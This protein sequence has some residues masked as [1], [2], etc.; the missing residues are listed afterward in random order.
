MRPALLL[1]EIVLFLRGLVV[2]MSRSFL[3][4]TRQWVTRVV[5]G[6]YS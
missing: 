6:Q 3:P 4:R 2:L 5:A 1:P